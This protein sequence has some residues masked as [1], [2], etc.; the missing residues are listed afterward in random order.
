MLG[1]S[2]VDKLIMIDTLG[3]VARTAARHAAH[4]AGG[5]VVLSVRARCLTSRF[6]LAAEYRAKKNFVGL[7][8][9]DDALLLARRGTVAGAA[10]GPK[11]GGLELRSVS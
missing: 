11:G 4:S 5:R 8:H 2:V 10:D 3:R 6:Q 9:L 1:P 7:M